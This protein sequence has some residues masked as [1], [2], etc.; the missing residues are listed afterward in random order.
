MSASNVHSFNEAAQRLRPDAP[1]VAPNG[2]PPD[3]TGMEARI[4]KLEAL[5]PT[6]ATKEDLMRETSAVKLEICR[7]DGSIRTDMHKEFTVQTWRI[8]GAMLTFGT[9]LTTAVF[10]I[11][12]YVK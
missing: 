7:I 6:L 4:S 3:N 11:A 2:E 10:F 9:L 1:P 8:I 5:I 12:R